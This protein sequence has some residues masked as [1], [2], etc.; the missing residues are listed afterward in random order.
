MRIESSGVYHD[1]IGVYYHLHSLQVSTIQNGWPGLYNNLTISSVNKLLY[2][3]LLRYSFLIV[4][5]GGMQHNFWNDIYR[6]KYI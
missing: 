5:Y 6:Y 4:Y 1:A 3:I 2:T